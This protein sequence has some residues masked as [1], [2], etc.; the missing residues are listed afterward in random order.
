MSPRKSSRSRRKSL[1]LSNHP[2][3][4]AAPPTPGRCRRQAFQLGGTDRLD[5]EAIEAGLL[6]ARLGTPAAGGALPRS[7]IRRKKNRK[8][9]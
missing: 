5:Q 8:K 1:D 9:A 3:G 2:G 7:K 4:P 6:R